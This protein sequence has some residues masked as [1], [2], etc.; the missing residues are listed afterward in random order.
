MAVM[1]AGVRALTLFADE[2]DLQHA[3]DI[4]GRSRMEEQTPLSMQRTGQA[5]GILSAL[6]LLEGNI[7]LIVAEGGIPVLLSVVNGASAAA[8][9]SPAAARIL[10]NGVRALGRLIGGS[11]EN[12]EEFLR[13]GGLESLISLMRAHHDKE[14]VVNACVAA[15]RALIDTQAGMKAVLNSELSKAVLEVLQAHPKYSTFT[16]KSLE[17]FKEFLRDERGIVNLVEAEIIK[18]CGQIIQHNPTSEPIV[19]ATVSLLRLLI[20]SHSE[21]AEEVAGECGE[22]LTRALAESPDRPEVC[23]AVMKLI[24]DLVTGDDGILEFMKDLGVTIAVQSVL[25]ANPHH[26]PVV[27]MATSLLSA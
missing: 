5:L 7:E 13:D 27:A 18:A 11:E 25:E 24:K 21:L 6:A 4:V 1:D 14:R 26:K 16:V 22:H 23:L 19:G 10:E 15:V 3:M 9:A 8:H 20:S 2:K 12:A 17:L